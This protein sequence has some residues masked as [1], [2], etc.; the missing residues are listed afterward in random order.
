MGF[1]V[2]INVE[3]KAELEN[4]ESVAHMF[5][6]LGKYYDLEKPRSSFIKNQIITHLGKF[7]TLINAKEK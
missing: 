6:I 4:A 1:G 5:E 2:K 7:L 3:I